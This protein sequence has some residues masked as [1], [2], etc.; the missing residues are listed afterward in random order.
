M[1]GYLDV[2]SPRNKTIDLRDVLQC[3]SLDFYFLVK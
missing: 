3:A 2:S 1:F